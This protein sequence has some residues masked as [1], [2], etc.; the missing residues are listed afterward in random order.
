M[1]SYGLDSW[2]AGTVVGDV[3]E[4]TPLKNVINYPYK[5]DDAWG[6][7]GASCVIVTA[8]EDEIELIQ[9]LKEEGFKKGPWIKNWGHGGRRTAMFFKQLTLK[10]WEE[11]TE[12]RLGDYD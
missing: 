1:Y 11:K 8:N 6:R 5:A 7:S 9:K 12:M 3:T 2:C 10:D 4:D